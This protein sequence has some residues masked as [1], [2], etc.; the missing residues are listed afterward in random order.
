MSKPRYLIDEEGRAPLFQ[1]S[2]VSHGKWFR[3][4]CVGSSAREIPCE[5]VHTIGRGAKVWRA[6]VV[7]ESTRRTQKKRPQRGAGCA[8]AEVTGRS[9]AYRHN[10]DI[11]SQAA[12]FPLN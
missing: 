12:D 6:L 5:P 8:G 1:G 3:G 4:P 11:G 7:T 2:F 9:A 10:S